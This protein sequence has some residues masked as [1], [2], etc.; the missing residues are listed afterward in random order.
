MCVP[1][2]YMLLSWLRASLPVDLSHEPVRFLSSIEGEERLSRS[3][4]AHDDH[5]DSVVDHVF[6]RGIET[7]V[8]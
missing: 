2:S 5:D 1:V 3:M 6:Y 8:G 7:V 4:G